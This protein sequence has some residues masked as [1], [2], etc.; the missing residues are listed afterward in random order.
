MTILLVSTADSARI[1]ADELSTYDLPMPLRIWPDT[2]PLEDITYAIAA[3][4]PHGLLATLPNLQAILSLWAGVDHITLDPNWPRAVPIYRM[5]EP[6]LTQGMV[7]FVMSQ[8]L[9]LHLM[10][11]QIAANARI[12]KWDTGIRGS[13]G[14]E[15][16]IPDRTVGVLGLGEM[17][18]NSAQ[19]L[20]RLGFQT[21]GWSRSA[22]QLDGVECLTGVDG[23][24]TLLSRSDILVN[25]LPFTPETENILNRD[26]LRRLPKGA[27]LVNVGRGQHVVDADLIDLLEEGHLSHAVLDVYRQEPL[28]ADHPFWG[29]PNI[30][31]VPHIASITRVKTG[32]QALIRSLT[33]LQAGKTP[34][35]HYNPDLGY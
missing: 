24:N 19:A 12:G 17:G 15:P 32:V 23:F 10:N 35:G 20:S 8:V 6:G 21:L 34:D 29:H 30:T 27:G 5:I 28:P 4:P 26:T 22:K 1:W 16:L 2:G 7:E 31:A 18:R 25:L 33:L 9:N 14:S 3:K 13:F 11:Y